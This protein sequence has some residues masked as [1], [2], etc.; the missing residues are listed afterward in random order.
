MRGHFPKHLRHFGR[1]RFDLVVN[2]SGL[3]LGEV[4]SNE[5]VEWNIEDPV[6][7]TYRRHRQICNEIEWHVM[8]LLLEK[9]NILPLVTTALSKP[10]KSWTTARQSISSWG[11][12][13]GRVR[14]VPGV[15]R[16]R[17]GFRWIHAKTGVLAACVGRM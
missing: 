16:T 2:M 17:A 6:R 7:R 1:A 13:R 14:A 11:C 4:G 3:P 9:F 5:L 12:F 8:N 10:L 15:N